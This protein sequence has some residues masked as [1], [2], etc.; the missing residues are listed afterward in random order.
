MCHQ[1]YLL[2]SFGPQS[3]CFT[4]SNIPSIHY[5]LYLRG[6]LGKNYLN[7]HP[8]YKMKWTNECISSVSTFTP[9]YFMT[10]RNNAKQQNIDFIQYVFSIDAIHTRGIAHVVQI[11]VTLT[12]LLRK[13]RRHGFPVTSISPPHAVLCLPWE[14]WHATT[15]ITPKTEA[16]IGP[17]PCHDTKKYSTLET[18]AIN[19]F[20]SFSHRTTVCRWL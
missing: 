15:T 1:S 10:A 3:M 11:I 8:L 17:R 12:L 14:I 6:P 18:E 9:E 16:I 4:Y 7:S 20:L 13:S 2:N 5:L 19:V